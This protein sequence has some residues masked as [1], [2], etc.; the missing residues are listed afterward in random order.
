[1]YPGKTVFEPESAVFDPAG[2]PYAVNFSSGGGFSNVYAVPSYQ[3]A[4]VKT[5][6]DDFQPEY[7]SYSG[8]VS[9]S[10]DVYEKP[11][12]VA[13]AGDSGGIYNRIGRGIPDVR[14]LLVEELD[15]LANQ[16]FART[17]RRE[18]RQRRRLFR[19]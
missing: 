17:G 7:P 16:L 11:D 9:D 8:L 2:F 5:F 19:R 1:M 14:I 12:V 10:D 15:L 4:A 6:F 18:R 3:A 13:L